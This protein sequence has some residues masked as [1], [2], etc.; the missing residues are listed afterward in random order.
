MSLRINRV[1]KK[2]QLWSYWVYNYDLFIL[3]Y[4]RTL[5][6]VIRQ[7]L[8]R[9]LALFLRIHYAGLRSIFRSTTQCYAAST[10]QLRSATQ[11]LR[12]GY[13]VLPDVNLSTTQ[14][15]RGIYVDTTQQLCG[16]YYW[17]RRGYVVLRLLY[18]AATQ[19]YV[20][21]AQLLRDAY[22]YTTQRLR[23]TSAITW[24][25]TLFVREY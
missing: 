6:V 15:L 5:Y 14:Q 12:I 22:V 23:G 24:T 17:L 18:V 16:P 3:Y 2:K 19:R 13:A 4:S 20:S 10:D 25:S 11:R 9:V 21:T 7:R 8:R 1:I